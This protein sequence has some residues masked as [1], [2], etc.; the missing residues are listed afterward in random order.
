MTADV[1]AFPLRPGAAPPR[2]ARRG[3]LIREA[4]VVVV[5]SVAVAL[6]HFARWLELE[7]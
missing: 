4:C 2:G 3:G 1:I 7:P 6:L 5:L